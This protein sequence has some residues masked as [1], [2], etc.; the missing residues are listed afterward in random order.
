MDVS[1]PKT[2]KS[3]YLLDRVSFHSLRH[4]SATLLIGQNIDIFT[5]SRRL[6]HANVSTT[7][8]IYTYALTKIDRKASDSLGSLL[9]KKEKT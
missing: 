6:G 7:L 9:S 1:I 4:T 3:N 5:V 2:E 8:N